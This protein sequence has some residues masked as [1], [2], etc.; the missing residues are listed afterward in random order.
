MNTLASAKL[1]DGFVYVHD[2]DPTIIINMSYAQEHNFIGKPLSGYKKNV[3]ILTKEAALAL[4]K[5]QQAVKKDGYT[6]VIYDA[7][8]PQ[9][10]VDEF[11][12]WGKD[13][14][15]DKM[16]LYYYPGLEKEDIFKRQYVAEKSTHT[17][18]STVD[19]TL[20][21]IGDKVKPITE[22]KRK[23]NDGS[24]VYYLNDGTLDMGT[25]FD[26]FDKASHPDSTLV[27][28]KYQARRLYLQE[29]MA[30][31]GFIEY[32]FEW[33]HFTLGNEP[34]PDTYFNFDVE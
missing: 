4:S 17:R 28:E 24:E 22:E 30:E 31:Q 21:P 7:Y 10:T 20:I 15:D 23:L 12:V 29:K 3:A 34:F 16:K 32:P 5:V 2:V 13:H 18:G 19:L 14:N 26:L 25:S 33:W 9:K 6:L 11:V 27:D 1:P 8:R